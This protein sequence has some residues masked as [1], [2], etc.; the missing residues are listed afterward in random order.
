LLRIDFNT[1]FEGLIEECRKVLLE[2]GYD[3]TVDSPDKL[4]NFMR[5]A[6][7]NGVSPLVVANIFFQKHTDSLDTYVKTGAVASEPIRGR[8]IDIINYAALIYALIEETGE[9]A[10]WHYSLK[11]DIDSVDWSK[12]KDRE[13]AQ[14]AEIN[15]FTEAGRREREDAIKAERLKAFRGDWGLQIP[16]GVT[17][18]AIP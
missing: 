2:K 13:A 16:V 11:W 8:I 6:E 9:T 3:Y 4:A 15:E 7:R 10:S 12:V 1:L 14:V 18:E 5:T 17:P